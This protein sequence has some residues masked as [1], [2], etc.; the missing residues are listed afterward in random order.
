ME[1]L[2]SNGRPQAA[3]HVKAN[4]TEDHEVVPLGEEGL[5]VPTPLVLLLRSHAWVLPLA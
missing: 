4:L 3:C 1:G 2:V 5:S